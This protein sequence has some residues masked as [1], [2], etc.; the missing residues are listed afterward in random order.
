MFEI[1][2]LLLNFCHFSLRAWS[3]ARDTSRIIVLHENSYYS[4]KLILSIWEPFSGLIVF[5]DPGLHWKNGPALKRWYTI[6]NKIRR[7]LAA[8]TI[9]ARSSYSRRKTPWE[10]G[11][12]IYKCI[13]SPNIQIPLPFA[14]ATNIEVQGLQSTAASLLGGV[15]EYLNTLAAY[16][17]GEETPIDPTIDCLSQAPVPP[18]LAFP[19]HNFDTGV[20]FIW[21]IPRRNLISAIGTCLHRYWLRARQPKP[22][23]V[24]RSLLHRH[25][26]RQVHRRRRNRTRFGWVVLQQPSRL[27][28]LSEFT[29]IIFRERLDFHMF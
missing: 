13:A 11:N 7:S 28:S 19:I 4:R 21:L 25:L 17:V 26:H 23:Q 1:I 15:S 6:S 3:L 2:C 18:H 8:G 20:W 24:K 9:S 14:L 5:N 29:V 16:P 12:H 10:A 22:A 27:L